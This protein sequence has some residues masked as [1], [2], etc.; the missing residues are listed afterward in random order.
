MF[1]IF[2]K[3]YT[4]YVFYPFPTLNNIISSFPSNICHYISTQFQLF[5]TYLQSI[6]S[7]QHIFNSNISIPHLIFQPS[8][9]IA[10][11]HRSR[12]INF[13]SLR[14][15]SPLPCPH[16]INC[17]VKTGSAWR[18]PGFLPSL[19]LVLM[20][21]YCVIEFAH[22]AVGSRGW[23]QLSGIWTPMIVWVGV[24]AARPLL[25][26]V[27]AFFFVPVASRRD[28]RRQCLRP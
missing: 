2:L 8:N 14:P 4:L 21:V 25:T 3:L 26:C 22:V 5:L 23:I 27:I 28:W 16:K 12:K 10:D 19:S 20:N 11:L 9:F 24:S 15:S 7:F 13:T 1:I 18:H 17:A 6:Q